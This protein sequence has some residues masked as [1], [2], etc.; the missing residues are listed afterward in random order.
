MDDPD[1][2]A[3]LEKANEDP[4]AREAKDFM[5][6]VLSF[7]TICGKAV[8]HNVMERASTMTQMTVAHRFHGAASTFWTKKCL[9]K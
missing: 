6:K 3:L 5:N 7:L 8:P 1:F 2:R 4:T 9:P